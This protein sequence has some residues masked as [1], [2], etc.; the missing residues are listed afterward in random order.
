MK[1]RHWINLIVVSIGAAICALFA[2]RWGIDSYATPTCTAY[3]QSKGLTFVSYQLP[4]A[5]G[6][7]AS[8]LDINGD[9]IY[10]TNAGTTREVGLYSASGTG[11]APFL[12]YLALHPLFVFGI[13]F[14]CIALVLAALG[15][16]GTSEKIPAS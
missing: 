8:S 3:G 11:G 14:V 4:M 1:A 2:A 5:P 7:T 15:R 12:V 9:C 10:R 13:A 16:G 6:G